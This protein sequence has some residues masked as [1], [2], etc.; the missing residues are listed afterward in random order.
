[1]T[2]TKARPARASGAN[3]VGR[4]AVPGPVRSSMVRNDP[5][6]TA[7][8]ASRPADLAEGRAGS[9]VL[10]SWGLQVAGEDRG[11]AQCN[12]K[13]E[14]ASRGSRQPSVTL[15]SACVPHVN[16]YRQ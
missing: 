10:A 4:R 2:Y 11:T 9:A 15:A 8:A 14:T 3:L 7:G 13:L 1:M 6:A 16:T 5:R 12:S